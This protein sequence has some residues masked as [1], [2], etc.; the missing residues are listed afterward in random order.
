VHSNWGTIVEGLARLR[1]WME[2]LEASG[3]TSGLAAMF[4]VMADLHSM[5]MQHNEAVAAA[6]RAVAIAQAVGDD[7][8]LADAQTYRGYALTFLGRHAEA[9]AVLAEAIRLGEATGAWA[10]LPF[11]LEAMHRVAFHAGEFTACRR[12]LDRAVEIAAR[13]GDPFQLVA[14]LQV[15]GLLAFCRGDWREARDDLTRS[16]ALCRQAGTLAIS[17]HP[18]LSLARLCLATGEWAEGAGLIAESMALPDRDMHPVARDLAQGLLAQLDLLEGRPD[19][20]RTRI[21]SLSPAVYHD[22]LFEEIVP[23][24]YGSLLALASLELGEVAEAERVVRETIAHARATQSQPGLVE[25][26][27]AAARI[28]LRQGRSADAAMYLDEAL[29]LARAMP[30]PH[31]EARLLEVYGRLHAAGGETER[32]RQ[33]LRAALAIFQRLGARKDAERTAQ[34]Q[35]NLG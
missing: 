11:A 8:V 28:A 22:G 6:E 29:P 17:A 24:G 4:A 13:R 23:H 30:N 5:S 19:A 20:A 21:L 10:T 9:R 2:V 3:P 33:S 31:A 16:L 34:L 15:H 25:A 18:P 32:A 7:R 26:L 27:W 35:A 12:S 14:F 1:A